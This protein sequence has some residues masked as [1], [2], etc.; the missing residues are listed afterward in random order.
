[1][2]DINLT[3][4]GSSTTIDGV[5]F[6]NTPTPIVSGTGG[7]FTFL[8]T[9]SQG[10]GVVSEGFNS[11]VSSPTTDTD[12][13]KTQAL[14]LGA[15]Q[16]VNVNGT[17]YYTFRLDI[18]EPNGQD[19]PFVTLNDF[20][21]YTSTNQATLANFNNT[22][23]ELGAGFVKV[24][25]MDAGG[26]KTLLMIDDSTT[27]GGSG[28]DNYTVLIPT[29]VFAGQDPNSYVTLFTQMGRVDPI[30]G[31]SY[32]EDS[33]FE[34]WRALTQPFTPEGAPS[35]DIQKTVDSDSDGDAIF[36]ESESVA[37][38]SAATA[39]YRYV[40]TN[41]SPNAATDPLSN[42]T[43]V[44]N[45]GTADT[46]DDLHLMTN[47]V[48]NAA[49]ASIVYSG[50]DSDNLLELGET[51][52][53]TANNVTI[54]AGDGGTSLVNT[55]TVNG[56]DNEGV[57]V[58]DS[59]T[60][61]VVRADV[62]PVI[63]IV[64]GGPATIAEGGA[65]VTWTFT[66]TNNSVSTDPITVTALHDDKLGDLLAA[67]IAAN[68]GNPI[69]L[70]P[71]GT[72]SFD[73][74]P[75]GNLVLDG[76]E[77]YTNV[78]TVTGMDD[79]GTSD[80]GTDNHT[81]TATDV[82]PVIDIVKTVN[83]NGDDIF[84]DSETV[85]AGP[86]T[87]IYRYA[88]TN[89]SVSTDPLTINSLF[90]DKL[91]NIN[92]A[93][94]TSGDADH[95]GIFDSGERWVF[96]V[97]AVINVP[98]GGTLLN[99][100]TV[101][102]SDDEGNLVFDSDTAEVHGLAG[103][104]VRTPGFWSNLGAQFW[105]GIVGNE[106]KSGPSFPGGELLAYNDLNGS[107]AGNGNPNAYIILGGDH[108]ATLEAGELKISLAD[109]FKFINASTK[110]QQDGRWMLACDAVAAELNIRAGNP[111]SDGV[112][113][114]DPQHLLNDAVAWLIATSGDNILTTAE[115]GVGGVKTSDVR[116]Q[117]PYLSGDPHSASVMH[118]QL[119]NYNNFGSVF[120]VV[121]ADDGDLV[122]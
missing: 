30:S 70:A 28:R 118:T 90:D 109:A 18:N 53:I 2:T 3:A 62:A 23:N 45:R 55:A 66:I 77:T 121:Y 49:I 48:I 54:P 102:A 16:T 8:A 50:G 38:G 35:I 117:S 82:A 4:T 32:T 94:P 75:A 112:H 81:I 33:G 101:N 15:L 119:D 92:F 106:T 34:E 46:S 14:Q 6:I 51:W 107:G 9:Q 26:D 1:M 69:V 78:V 20:K 76:G 73:Y 108:D 116:W 110:Q 83:A 52:T 44:D 104:G 57:A 10:N 40:L 7:Y 93:T 56:A 67:A 95:D 12:D 100:A 5:T 37:E 103:P 41:T 19:A 22:S 122:I 29:S 114:Y 36:H 27:G 96:D 25:D 58:T 86:R 98:G 31:V 68:G 120:G 17:D 74:N 97:S 87:V 24:Y 13:S 21:L 47:G 60:A 42:I 84:H 79:E 89:N 91:G 115:L 59:D 63:D 105:D 113:A 39:D 65:D 64:K 71:G 72:F 80:T 43:V 111:G 88:I 99:T 85:A 11:G 61:T